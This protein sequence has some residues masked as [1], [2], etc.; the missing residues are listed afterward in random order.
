VRLKNDRRNFSVAPVTPAAYGSGDA[1]GVLQSLAGAVSGSKQSGTLENLVVVDIDNQSAP[2]DVFL[3]QSS[4]TGGVDNAAYAPSDAEILE[5]VGV[6]EVDA[7][8]Y[9][10]VGASSVATIPVDLGFQLDSSTTV[11]AQIVSRGTPT[12][13]AANSLRFN[14]VISAD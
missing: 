14:F 3:F 10:T 4:V 9:I 8:D 2:I 7:L 6:V 12:Y 11:Y 13:G 1:I 5:C